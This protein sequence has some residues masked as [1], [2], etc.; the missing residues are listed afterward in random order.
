MAFT[1][2][3]STSLIC[4]IVFNGYGFGLY[5]KLDRVHIYAVVLAVWAIQLLWSKPWLEH[6][7]FGPF[8]WIWRSLTYWKRQPMLLERPSRLAN[9]ATA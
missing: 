3:L 2:Y 4:T 7:R 9:A 1:N 8:E 6:F 5:R